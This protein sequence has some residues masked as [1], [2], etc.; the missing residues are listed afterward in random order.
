MQIINIIQLQKEIKQNQ[1]ASELP[2]LYSESSTVFQQESQNRF[3]L[4]G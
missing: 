1:M 3:L 2:V 4:R